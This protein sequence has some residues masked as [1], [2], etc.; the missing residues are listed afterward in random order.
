MKHK[1]D[2]DLDDL[3]LDDLD[4]D[5]LD[6]DDDDY[7]FDLRKRSFGF[8][9]DYYGGLGGGQL[10]GCEFLSLLPS[11]LAVRG[12]TSPLSVLSSRRNSP[13]RECPTRRRET[14]PTR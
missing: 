2:L 7:S 11:R 6:D 13:R 10:E 5:D 12:L 8:G 1:R 9:G 14:R 3:D 4:L